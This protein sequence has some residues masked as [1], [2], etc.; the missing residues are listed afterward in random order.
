MTAG[1]GVEGGVTTEGAAGDDV[2][3]GSTTAG[4]SVEG[5]GATEHPVTVLSIPRHRKI[6]NIRVSIVGL[7]LT[8]MLYA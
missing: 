8:V 2:T 5:G 4:G 3:G 6:H 7:P 1:G